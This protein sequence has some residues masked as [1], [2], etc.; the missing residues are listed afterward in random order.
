MLEDGRLLFSSVNAR[1][2]CRRVRIPASTTFESKVDHWQPLTL[3]PTFSTNLFMHPP[4]R[5]SYSQQAAQFANPA[6]R[7]LLKIMVKK[8][9]N[10]AVSVDVMNTKDFLQV[11]DVVGPFVCL[12]KA[13]PPPKIL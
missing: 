2:L 4:L 6:A 7:Q 1:V 12:I 11:I 3:D 13:L 5:Q 9:P 8:N 10:L